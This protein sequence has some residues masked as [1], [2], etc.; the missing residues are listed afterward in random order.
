MANTYN[1]LS[2]RT[3]TAAH[4]KHLEHA[5]PV[6]V[7]GAHGDTKKLTSNK[8]KSITFRRPIPKAPAVGGIAEGVTPP[9]TELTYEDVAFTMGQYG[10]ITQITDVVHDLAED[11]VLNDAAMINGEQ[12]GATTEALLWGKLK[13]GTNVI[14]ASGVAGRA[15]VAAKLSLADHRLAI[16]AL[17]A[18]K[19]K[20]HTKK[21]EST[22]QYHTRSIPAC[23]IAFAS[24]DIEGQI[25]DLPGFI[26]V[27]DYKTTVSEHEI[28][29]CEGVRFILSPELDGWAAAGAAGVDVLPIVY[30]ARHAYG[31]VALK[32]KEAIDTSIIPP[33]KKDKSDVLGQRGYAGW[34]CYW[35]GGILNDAWMVRVEVA[36]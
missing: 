20:K 31:N 23:Y 5:A 25:R 36:E 18:Q 35:T 1:G 10:D 27:E 24:T 14:Y 2:Q 21:V 8:A 15:S 29:S 28:G 26:P 4:A 3:N 12:A 6:I 13:A 9:A 19:G 17:K 32:G 16:K 33:G 7:L 30:C 34:K 11:P 22:V